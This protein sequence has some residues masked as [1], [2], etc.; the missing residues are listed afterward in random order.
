MYFGA[1]VLLLDKRNASISDYP[2]E[3]RL[4]RPGLVIRTKNSSPK[5]FYGFAAVLT[6]LKEII[7]TFGRIQKML[8]LGWAFFIISWRT[9]MI[10]LRASYVARVA[11]SYEMLRI[12]MSGFAAL[13]V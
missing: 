2:A 9:T 1:F 8:N 10:A 13:K 3:R 6:V 4:P 11:S 12:A 5:S 7:S